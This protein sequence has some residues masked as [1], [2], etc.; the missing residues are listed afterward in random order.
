MAEARDGTIGFWERWVRRWVG[1]VHLE[2]LRLRER[3]VEPGAGIRPASAFIAGVENSVARAEHDAVMK[4]ISKTDAR[5]EIVGVGR[6][7]AAT[8]R[9]AD[10]DKLSQRR[11]QLGILAPRKKQSLRAHIVRSLLVASFPY[12]NEQVVAQAQIQSQGLRNLK[13]ILHV[14]SIDGALVIHIVHAGV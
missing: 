7:Q 6:N 12:G 1:A 2:A 3:W 10:R 4:L 13:V 9:G 8:G 11:R 5:R 14:K